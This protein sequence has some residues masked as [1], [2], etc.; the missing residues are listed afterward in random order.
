MASNAV[1]DKSARASALNAC[2]IIV[3]ARWL[4]VLQAG[5][6][7]SGADIFVSVWPVV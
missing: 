1:V 4:H 2:Q 3:H 5:C 6:L 7:L